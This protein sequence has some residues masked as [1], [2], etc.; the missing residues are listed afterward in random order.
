MSRHCRTAYFC[1]PD[2]DYQCIQDNE[3]KRDML[4]RLHKKKCKK[5]G[6]GDSPDAGVQV[7]QKNAQ[8]KNV[9]KKDVEIKNDFHTN[10]L[11]QVKEVVKIVEL[12]QIS[13]AQ[14]EVANQAYNNSKNS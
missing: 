1:C 8:Y 9:S 10:S 12:Y 6:R 7:N 4:M 2:C 11:L 14:I 3:K 5:T 13:N